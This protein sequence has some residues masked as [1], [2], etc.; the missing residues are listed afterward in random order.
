MRYG[1]ISAP[2]VID[3][4]C[5]LVHDKFIDDYTKLLG[6]NY[7]KGKKCSCGKAISNRATRCNRCEHLGKKFSQECRDKL[8]KS[9]KGQ[10]SVMKG[11]KASPETRVKQRISH[12]GKKPWNTG[13][14]GCYS[15]EWLKTQSNRVKKWLSTPE[16]HPAWK[17]G[18]TYEEYG[19]EFTEGL[20]EQVRFRDGYKC[21]ICG[22]PQV[23]SR[24]ALAI[25]HIDYNKKNNALDNL[26]TLCI[27]CHTET[28][29]KRE[30]WTKYF[31][32]QICGLGI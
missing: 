26:A 6:S 7:T 22:C 13:K 29:W 23:E 14:T 2:D 1:D 19:R 16:N 15:Q 27:N 30:Y 4:T 11:K 5:E 18:I 28:N 10:V 24:K 21:R 32:E 17:G 12:L 20:K 25:H 3:T 9:H 8:S 31:K